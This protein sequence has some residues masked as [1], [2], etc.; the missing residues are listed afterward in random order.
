MAL[1]PPYRPEVASDEAPIELIE[2]MND[3]WQ[4]SP[5]AR[6]EIGPIKS[7]LKK[8]TRGISSKNFFDNLLS[9]MEQY[10]N[11]LE[12]LV[13]EKTNALI[14]EKQKADEILYQLLPRTVADQLKVGIETKPE[15]FQAVTI[16]FSD[17]VGFTALSSMSTPMQ[18][19]DFLNDLYTCFDAII[20]NHDVYKV[21]T[22]GKIIIININRNNLLVFKFYFKKIKGDAYLVASGCPNR[23]GNEHSREIARM[24]L[25]LRDAT[26]NFVVKHRPE[27][28]V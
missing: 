10:A 12:Q 15:A 9:R 20:E 23:N 16:F 21:E 1:I 13:D 24:A 18:V 5:T 6:P 14:E 28:K 11:N 8:I 3:C 27:H 26:Q 4:E 19:V 17:I 2:L 7:R 22:I 25:E